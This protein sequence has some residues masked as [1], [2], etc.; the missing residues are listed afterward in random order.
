MTYKEQIQLKKQ[1]MKNDQCKKKL[2]LMVSQFYFNIII[3][4]YIY[5]ALY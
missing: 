3:F 4:I 1:H 2:D 5:N